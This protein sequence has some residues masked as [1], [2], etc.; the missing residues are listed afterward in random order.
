[1]SKSFQTI[2]EF[3]KISVGESLT[4]ISSAG[5]ALTVGNA[6]SGDL[7]T[8]DSTS[9]SLITLPSPSVGLNFSFIVAATAGHVI[10]APSASI[11]GSVV[12]ATPSTGASLTTGD[13]K[14]SIT[15]TTGS[16]V[17][18]SLNLVCD[19]RRYYLKGSVA[20]GRSLLFA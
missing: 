3:Q 10:T 8:L 18:D 20:N 11:V 5:S 13:A 9:G 14:T 17:G 19:G 15:A 1:M 12:S 4:Q 16:A 7:I 2:H 6:N